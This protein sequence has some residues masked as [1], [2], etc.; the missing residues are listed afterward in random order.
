MII[1]N[2]K[3]LTHFE[4]KM[5][6]N[7]KKGI[8]ESC[9]TLYKRMGINRFV[10]RRIKKGKGISMRNLIKIT[11]YIGTSPGMYAKERFI[12]TGHLLALLIGLGLG[13]SIFMFV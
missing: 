6:T 9:E 12:D 11:N 4:E 13:I 8:N 7:S 5:I 10:I 1:D 3:L 2:K